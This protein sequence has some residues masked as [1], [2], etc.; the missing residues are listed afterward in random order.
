VSGWSVAGTGSGNVSV[1]L[2][3]LRPNTAPR[4]WNPVSPADGRS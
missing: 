2:R 1:F 4:L 3:L